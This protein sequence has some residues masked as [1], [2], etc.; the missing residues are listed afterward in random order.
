[1]GVGADLAAELSAAL[2]AEVAEVVVEPLHIQLQAGSVEQ[3]AHGD[4]G[5]FGDAGSGGIGLDSS[6]F[7]TSTRPSQAVLAVARAS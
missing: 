6:G 4:H 3:G 5:S 1:L 7:T 2:A